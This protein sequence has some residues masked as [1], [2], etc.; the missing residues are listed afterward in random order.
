MPGQRERCPART[1]IPV[2]PALNIVAVGRGIARWC[3]V[4]MFSLSPKA[5]VSASASWS[6][7]RP[8]RGRSAISPTLSS[9]LSH[10]WAVSWCRP[11]SAGFTMA[12]YDWRHELLSRPFTRWMP[13][14]IDVENAAPVTTEDHENEKDSVGQR[15]HGKVSIAT[16]DRGDWSATCPTSERVLFVAVTSAGKSF[17]ERP[18][19]PQFRQRSMDARRHPARCRTVT[20]ESARLATLSVVVRAC[21][22]RPQPTVTVPGSP[23]TR[24]R[25]LQSICPDRRRLRSMR[26]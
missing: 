17:A 5:S 13:S 18:R 19:E 1:N 6:E 14:D 25:D 12:T 11:K 26:L 23:E 20:I 7:N 8:T 16:V 9:A 15:G 4:R 22:V 10:G 21:S 2:L 3:Y 24:P